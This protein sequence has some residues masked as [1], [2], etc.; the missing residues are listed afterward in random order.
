MYLLF[1]LIPFMVAILATA[2]PMITHYK[3]IK[4]LHS[5]G[6]LSDVSAVFRLWNG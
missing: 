4:K 6:H 5:A 1:I 3:K 2:I